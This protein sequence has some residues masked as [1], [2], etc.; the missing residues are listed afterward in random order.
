MLLGD[1]LRPAGELGGGSGG[2]SHMEVPAL[3]VVPIPDVA[4]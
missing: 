3:V 2:R 4:P 1:A